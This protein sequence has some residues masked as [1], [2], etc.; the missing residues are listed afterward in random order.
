MAQLLSTWIDGFIGSA[1]ATGNKVKNAFGKVIPE[2]KQ[3]FASDFMGKGWQIFK[4]GGT[5]EN[6]EYTFEIDNIKIRKALIAHE[7]IIDQIRAICGSLGISQACGKVK[8]VSENELFYFLNMEG[9][10]THGYGGFQVG[11]LVRCQRLTANGINGYWVQVTKIVTNENG[12]HLVIPKDQ[13][14]NGNIYQQT[15]G[16]DADNVDTTKATGVAMCTP[17]AG[18]NLVQ[19]GNVSDKTR[20]SAIYIH[21]DGMG[22]PAIDMLEGINSRSFAGKM[23]CR[24]GGELPEGGFGFYCE[25]GKIIS[26]DG[27]ETN[28]RFSPDGTFEL[29]KGAITY[30]EGVVTLSPEVVINWGATSQA[31]VQYCTS[32]S[33]S[34]QPTEGW[35]NT[36]PTLEQGKWLWTR[37]KY[38]D[39]TYTYSVSY[40]PKNGEPGTSIKIKGT[41][42][43]IDELPT[44][45]EDDSDCYI[46]GQ[47]LYV[48]DGTN[49]QNVGQIKGDKGDTGIGIVSVNTIYALGIYGN[50]EPDASNFKYDTM[51]S[52]V[53]ANN[54]NRYLW[55][56]DKVTYT[57]GSTALTGKY[58]VGQCSTLTNVVEQYGTS[59][60]NTTQPTTWEDNDFP[61][62]L[63]EGTWIWSRD[64]VKWKDNSV[65]YSEAKIK[66][67]IAKKGD[68]GD[69]GDKGI[70]ITSV[71]TFY[72]LNKYSQRIPIDN[73]FTYDKINSVVISENAEQ[74][75][76]SGDKVTYTDNT[77]AITGKY[78]LGQ[79]K[80]LANITEQY[81][82]SESSTT[83]PTDSSWVDDDF[84]TGLNEGTYIW[85]RNKI[86]WKDG[87]VTFSDAKLVGYI[88]KKGDKGDKGE[89]GQSLRP[90][91]LDYTAL[92]ADTFTNPPSGVTI[93]G[94][95]SADVPDGCGGIFVNKEITDDYYD[96]FREDIL[97]RLQPNTQYTISFLLRK[98]DTSSTADAKFAV[99]LYTGTTGSEFINLSKAVIVNGETK[100]LTSNVISLTHSGGAYT[101]Y[102]ITFT[103]AS[104]LSSLS[105]AYFLWRMYKGSVGLILGQMKVERSGAASEW[106]LSETD[107]FVALPTW[108]RQWD[109]TATQ[110]G[111]TY[112]VSPNAFFGKKE[113]SDTSITGIYL[114]SDSLTIDGE[115][116]TGFYAFDKGEVKVI[117]DP[118]KGEYKFVGE[119][120]ATK[121][122]FSNVSCKSLT[123]PN[124]GFAIDGKGTPIITQK[125][126]NTTL[127]IQPNDEAITL[128]KDNNLLVA[129][130]YFANYGG[131]KVG[132]II[133][134]NEENT[135]HAELD[136]RYLY[137]ADWTTGSYANTTIMGGYIKVIGNSS[138]KHIILDASGSGS[139]ARI[140]INGFK[141]VDDS[142]DFANIKQ[143]DVILG[144]AQD[145]ET[146]N[147]TISI[148]PMFWVEKVTE[149]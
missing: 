65:T 4:S 132:G 50:V 11:D 135:Y 37:T 92:T 86:T 31:N 57:N 147:K 70:G 84:P 144:K 148:R 56:A 34:T 47:D 35:S 36:I 98:I 117:I 119:I 48:W 129:I 2:M 116:R 16:N 100:V 12:F 115:T 134:Q 114:S 60:S 21:A 10:E 106:C 53:I 64:K 120:E 104:D 113:D 67:Y 139:Y 108:V 18:D 78:C 62:G 61:T 32:T 14:T 128:Y 133:L 99:I 143:Y 103:T 63:A 72:A 79:C 8:S 26:T 123:T 111:S 136:S 27:T 96:L 93:G 29:G 42:Q 94:I 20:Q 59:T 145:Y 33:G 46:I 41:K 109:G 126:S 73:A 77:T 107:K 43:S 45:P 44:P 55:S 71:N 121:G 90:N 138:D 87:N 130:G 91:L 127:K 9:E 81:G 6:P 112:I 85:S 142:T 1:K 30:K 28:Y 24:L 149:N 23:V 49:W 101:R 88:A 38:P 102:T 118:T 5:D 97:S 83:K 58:C 69:K 75:L 89:D 141:K 124:G 140:Q 66:G 122:T 110:I 13:F 146:R 15:S 52:I 125:A 74:Y 40:C 80:D 105:H 137:M 17:S 7:L 19:Y 54:A 39:G 3:Y 76:W 25:N 51:S 68:K 131:S 82:T 22:R 95:R